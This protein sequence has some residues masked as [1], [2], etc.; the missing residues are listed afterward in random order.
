MT[1]LPHDEEN[2]IIN[3]FAAMSTSSI[4]KMIT[5]ATGYDGSAQRIAYCYLA[6]GSFVQHLKGD[7]LLLLILLFIGV[8]KQFLKLNPKNCTQLFSYAG[9]IRET[10]PSDAHCDWAGAG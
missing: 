6:S 3:G 2:T 5:V 1:T 10:F 7:E 9:Q 4:A 8:L